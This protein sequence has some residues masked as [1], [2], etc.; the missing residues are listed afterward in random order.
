MEREHD[1]AITQ[2]KEIL[3]SEPILAHPDWD[4]PFEIHTDASNYAIGV[5]LCQIIDG[6]ERVI[7]Y[8]LFK[9][10]ARCGEEIRYHAKGVLG[11]SLGY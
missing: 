10:I 5:V 8:C 1:I 4:L 11:C 3:V 6:K 7:G 9:A 2:L